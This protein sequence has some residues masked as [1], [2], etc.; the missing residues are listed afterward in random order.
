[1]MPT[2]LAGVIEADVR[3]PGRLYLLSASPHHVIRHYTN[4]LGASAGDA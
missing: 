3:A 4:E 1:M 2:R